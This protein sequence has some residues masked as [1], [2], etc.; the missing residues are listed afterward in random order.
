MG[1]S[2]LDPIQDALG[3]E[4]LGLPGAETVLPVVASVFLPG[5]GSAI[6]GALGA[7]GATASAIGGAVLGGAGSALA[8]GDALTGALLGGAGGFLS[9]GGLSGAGDGGMLTMDQLGSLAGNPEAIQSYLDAGYISQDMLTNSMSAFT[10]LPADA[11]QAYINAGFD[12][13]E[14][15]AASLSNT[16]TNWANVA[17]IAKN[18]STIAKPNAGTNSLTNFLK[19]PSWS[20]AGNLLTDNL[21]NLTNA[22]LGLYGQY[23]SAQSAKDIAAQNAAMQKPW[24]DAGTNALAQITPGIQSGGEFR[25]DYT[26]ADYQVDPYNKWLQSQGSKAIERS[27]AA[28]GTLGSGNV[29]AELSKYNQNVAG[30]GFADQWNREQQGTTNKFNRLASVANLGPTAATNVMGGNAFAASEGAKSK[31]GM[32]NTL[33]NLVNSW[34][35]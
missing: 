21:G 7:T 29:L 24:L 15:G 2:F 32:T 20:G 17:D 35:T 13:V 27:A 10:S 33:S 34:G 5:L 12:P 18:V 14:I 26:V 6:G 8:G 9:G 30:A 3:S 1:C 31:I 25:K 19:D 11:Q 23:Q 22:G 4:G 28:K 16:G